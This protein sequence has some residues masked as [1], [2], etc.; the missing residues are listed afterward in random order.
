M[1][2]HRTTAALEH[3]FLCALCPL[4]YTLRSM[5]YALCPR[6]YALCLYRYTAAPQHFLTL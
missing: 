6:F 4:V 2:H 5:L 3:F 1:I